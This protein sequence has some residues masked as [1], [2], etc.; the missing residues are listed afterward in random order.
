M[1]PQDVF[2]LLK[3]VAIGPSSWSY[4][5]L[6]ASLGMSSSQLHSAIKRAKKDNTLYERLGVVD[7]VRDGQAREQGGYLAGVRGAVW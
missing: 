3:L 1:K 6:S 5:G 2:V 7:S 4:A